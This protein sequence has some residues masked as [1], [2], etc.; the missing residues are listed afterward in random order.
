MKIVINKVIPFKGFKAITIWPFI[1]VREECIQRYTTT[2]DRHEEIHGRQQVEVLIVA[3]VIG[4]ALFFLGCGWW[5]LFMLPL[6]FV[7]Y[8]IEYLIRILL[9]RNQ[10][11]AYRNISFEQEAYTYETFTEY[12]NCRTPFEWITFLFK[13]TI[14]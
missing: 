9:Y 12:L 1:F 5:S 3:L 4:T 8:G 14:D 10:R 2:D 7:W 11:T 6:Y 13:K